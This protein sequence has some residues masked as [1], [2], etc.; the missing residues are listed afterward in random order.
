MAKK[1]I[2]ERLR[3]DEPTDSFVL[4]IWNEEY[5]EW[6]MCRA[7]KCV[8]RENAED[9]EEANFV[10]YEILKQLAHDCSVY[11]VRVVMG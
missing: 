8:R 2:V 11:D 4:E 7:A 5:Q 3:Y 6:G 9:G 1:R 10:H